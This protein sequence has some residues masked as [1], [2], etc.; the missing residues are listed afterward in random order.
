MIR[1]TRG[2]EPPELTAKRQTKLVLLRSLIQNTGKD[3]TSDDIDGYAIVG[4]ELWERQHFKCCY[5]ELREQNK[6]ND[7]EHFRPKGRAARA[8]GSTATHGY[9]WLAYSWENLFFSCRNCNQSPAKLD[10]FPLEVGSVAL[11]AEEAPDGG[12]K[13][14]LINPAVESGVTH[15]QFRP[16][17]AAGRVR[18]VPVPRNGSEKGKWTIQTCRLD[19]DELIDLYTQHVHLYV[20]P[21]VDA[22]RSAT[23]ERAALDA[24]WRRAVRLVSPTMQLAALSFDVLDAEFPE[25]ERVRLGLT[26]AP[27]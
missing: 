22:V 6:R 2:A 10:K 26:L 27:P 5:C 9:W 3:P 12:E 21:E 7:V 4:R 17:K 18:W 1:V 23:R 16:T 13:P 15:I 8:P 11:Q 24:A 25:A 14:L 19:R 20:G